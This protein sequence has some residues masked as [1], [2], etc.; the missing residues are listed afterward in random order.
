MKEIEINVLFE[1]SEM[2]VC[3]KPSGISSQSDKTGDYDMVNR[4]KNYLFQ[5]APAGGEPYI[6]LIH[7][8]D[9]PVGGIMVFAK[10]SFA[11]R[12]LSESIRSGDMRK[13][14][15]AVLNYDGTGELG[16]E[17]KL[18]TDYLAKDGRSNCSRITGEKD[19]NGKKAELYY[20]IK[21]VKE[22][23]SL[24]EIRLLTG[25]HHQIRL[26]MAAH[27]GGIWGDTKYNSLFQ[28]KSGFFRMGL[29]AY[30][31]EVTHPRSGKKLAFTLLPH[32]EP[33]D[34]FA[35]VSN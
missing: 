28:E 3:E 1:D 34:L 23:C 9:R 4:L 6:G 17:P 12:K 22:G 35:Y 32:G 25:R 2:I 26:Q 27:L 19:K 7:R 20:Q 11:A 14:Y 15:L 8:L 21:E 30:R 24:A 18:L 33:F 10:T 16:K 5:K 13:W 31:L 29:F